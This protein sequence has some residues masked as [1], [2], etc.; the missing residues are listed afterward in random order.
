MSIWGARARSE[1]SPSRY[2]SV[3]FDLGWKPDIERGMHDAHTSRQ[4]YAVFLSCTDRVCVRCAV[5]SYHIMPRKYMTAA[6]KSGNGSTSQI[7]TCS[8]YVQYSNF[9]AKKERAL[10]SSYHEFITRTSSCPFPRSLFDYR[11]LV[12]GFIACP[13][14]YFGR[15]A[16]DWTGL[17]WIGLRLNWAR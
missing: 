15:V 11:M 14:A 8:C 13:D 3:L 7:F 16:C 1:L 2:L 10:S 9:Q 4:V 6:N 5:A 12:V 17:D